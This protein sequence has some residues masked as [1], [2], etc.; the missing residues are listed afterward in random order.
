MTQERNRQTRATVRYGRD[1][2]GGT[3]VRASGDVSL[4]QTAGSGVGGLMVP[5]HGWGLRASETVVRLSASR[6]L[7]ESSFAEI[8]FGAER[9]T[10]SIEPINS[11]SEIIVNGAFVAGGA[12]TRGM[13]SASHVELESDWERSLGPVL[14][15]AGWSAQFL[16][17]ENGFTGNPDGTYVFSSLGA[18][19]RSQPSAFRL[20]VSPTPVA[21]S[22]F[23][24]GLYVQS[25]WRARSDL[26]IAGGLRYEAQQ[27]VVDGF[28][29]GPRV[30][31]AWSPGSSG[32]TRIDAGFG[33]YHA[34][35]DPSVVEETLLRDGEHHRELNLTDPPYPG[36]IPPNLVPVLPSE[37]YR[38]AGELRKPRLTVGALS[39]ARQ[40]GPVTITARGEVRDGIREFRGVNVNSPDDAGDRPDKRYANV[41]EV[42][43]EGQSR[44]RQFRCDVSGRG[45]FGTTVVGTYLLT[46]AK[47]DGN[48]AFSVPADATRPWLEW[49][50]SG[51]D[52]RHR[53][54]GMVVAQPLRNRLWLAVNFVASSG[55]PYTMTT[56]TDANDDGLF[57][58]RPDGVPRNS[59]RGVGTR[60]MDLHVRW[61]GRGISNA[62][63]GAPRRAS[64]VVRMDIQNLLNRSNWAN[65]VG[66]LTSPAFGQPTMPGPARQ[67]T[68][69]FSLGFD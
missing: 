27:M 61:R 26:S 22:Q 8:R 49:G 38:L 60:S 58:D 46:S 30:S 15:S 62:A 3:V 2:G 36:A 21:V 68:L 23:R 69:G 19:E 50:P 57:I 65:F 9:A 44:L 42:T 6:V 20:K 14:L 11:G 66:V 48:G 41:V 37:I 17:A 7:N 5:E 54:T 67:V 16:A 52:I 55:S 45:P 12:P 47:N 28:D 40:V 33:V 25:Q 43:S 35:L 64:W 53:V 59:L 10:T 63:D 13:R 32:R 4:G 51:A 56:G 39:V 34:W 1:T 24:G 29:L 18:W 31:V